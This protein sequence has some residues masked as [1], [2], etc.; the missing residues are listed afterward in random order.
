M[1]SVISAGLRERVLIRDGYRC[2]L[3]GEAIDPVL[4]AVDSMSGTG[5]HLIPVSQGGS[6]TPG[7]PAA[8]HRSCNSWRQ[9]ASAE[10]AREERWGWTPGT[11]KRAKSRS[12][13][14]PKQ[15]PP[16]VTTLDGADGVRVGP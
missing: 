8:A 3:C 16:A 7:H 2:H 15:R 10:A 14:W 6:A 9:D 4:P 12:R 13:S 5:D 1:R 11:T